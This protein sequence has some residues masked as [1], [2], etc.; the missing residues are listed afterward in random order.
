MG[1]IEGGGEWARVGG[2]LKWGLWSPGGVVEAV[3]EG[4]GETG[5]R[6]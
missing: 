4:E 3:G 1:I 6:W 2:A 5:R